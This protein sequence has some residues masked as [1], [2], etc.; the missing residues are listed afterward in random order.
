MFAFSMFPW[1]LMFGVDPDVACM[2]NLFFMIVLIFSIFLIA[3]HFSGDYSGVLAAFIITTYPVVFSLSR[4][5]LPYF[6]TL[7]MV[8]L[9]VLFL[10]RSEGF[11]NT[12]Y[13]FLSGFTSGAAVLMHQSAVFSLFIPYIFFLFEAKSRPK[14]RYL[15][16]LLSVFVIGCF[17]WAWIFLVKGNPYTYMAV[18][19]NLPQFKAVTRGFIRFTNLFFT[20][21][22][23]RFYSI[24]FMI[25]CIPLVFRKTK[26]F[27]F[28]CA[29]YITHTMISS[30]FPA[31]QTPRFNIASLGAMA[32]ITSL[33]IFNIRW[34]VTRVLC[35]A[36]VVI[37]GL[38]QYLVISYYPYADRY[39]SDIQPLNRRTRLRVDDQVNHYG[40]PQANKTYWNQNEL[41]SLLMKDRRDG[42]KKRVKTWIIYVKKC[43]KRE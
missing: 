43:A 34:R 25:S 22:L 30:F 8:S 41:L 7:A 33:G 15:N 36:L 27:F 20:A 39:Y 17:V 11:T 5:C 4:W 12:K 31:S 42:H 13:S 35:S 19:N 16:F 10:I 6:S 23:H 2:S 28:L 37:F 21:Q 1:Y 32:L 9:T 3:R 40:L 38:L 26:L 24:V 29:W 14:V 18:N